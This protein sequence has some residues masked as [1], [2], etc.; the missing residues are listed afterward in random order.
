MFA[1]VILLLSISSNVTIF[2]STDQIYTHEFGDID[3][4]LDLEIIPINKMKN[5][6]SQLQLV[7]SVKQIT[8]SGQCTFYTW[9]FEGF[10]LSMRLWV[11][12]EN[13]SYYIT[14]F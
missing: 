3:S 4:V 14:I 2:N 8:H 9:D 6:Y 5:W 12:Y 13:G 1:V 11:L 10:T 7:G